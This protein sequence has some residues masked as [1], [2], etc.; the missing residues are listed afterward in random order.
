MLIT[1]S[2]FFAEV[3]KMAIEEYLTSPYFIVGVI[4]TLT[5]YFDIWFDKTDGKVLYLIVSITT[6]LISIVSIGRN[7]LYRRCLRA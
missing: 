3:E 2:L 1:V 7:I 4:M 6:L 5:S